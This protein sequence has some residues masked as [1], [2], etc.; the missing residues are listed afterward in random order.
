MSLAPLWFGPLTIVCQGA[1]SICLETPVRATVLRIKWT[2]V[3]STQIDRAIY[4]TSEQ[5]PI[6]EEENTFF[7]NEAVLYQINQTMPAGHYNYP[8]SF[9]L[10]AG[11]PG[12]FFDDRKLKNGDRVNVSITYM[13][14]VCLVIPGAKDLKC[15]HKIVIT[16]A[17]VHAMVPLHDKK[18]KRFLTATGKLKMEFWIDKSVFCPCEVFQKVDHIKVKLMRV[19]RIR[20]RHE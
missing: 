7:K 15:S 20:A 10:P 17:V 14:K 13:V 3:E 12:R 16:G 5:S 9:Q 18:S 4:P 8:F 11:L 6:V 2:G 1:V 19:L